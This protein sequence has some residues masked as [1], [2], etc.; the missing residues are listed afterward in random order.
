MPRRP[1]SHCRDNHAQP[2]DSTSKIIKTLRAV[3]VTGVTWP[4]C[5]HGL[6]ADAR[7]LGGSPCLRGL[8]A[9]AGIFYG[10]GGFIPLL[11][12]RR[13]GLFSQTTSVWYC[14]KSLIDSRF[15]PNKLQVLNH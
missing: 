7:P 11:Q 2:R 9:A 13:R 4:P 8:D 5:L 15:L 14:A 3:I 12:C 6:Y 1:P 10:F